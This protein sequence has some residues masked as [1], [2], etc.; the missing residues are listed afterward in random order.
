M[1]SP[2]TDLKMRT[3]DYIT[4]WQHSAVRKKLRHSQFSFS[5]KIAFTYTWH[6][7]NFLISFELWI[8]GGTRSW[9]RSRHQRH[10]APYT[11]YAISLHANT[12]DLWVVFL[13]HQMLDQRFKC[14]IS[15]P[16]VTICL[17]HLK[18]DTLRH[19]TGHILSLITW[20]LD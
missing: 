20:Q 17:V 19:M 1:R 15:H 18:Q 3:K 14:P 16:A 10:V 13:I 4:L 8:K 9:F 6:S 5:Y 2:F 7:F 11:A 12:Y